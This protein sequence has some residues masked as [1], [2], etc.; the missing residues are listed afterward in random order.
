[1]NG[2]YNRNSELKMSLENIK[3]LIIEEDEI[4][5]IIIQEILE[6]EGARVKF[7]D[8][9]EDVKI[10]SIDYHILL[11]NN[12]DCIENIDKLSKLD[13]NSLTI[14]L[15]RE[16]SN[17][18]CSWNLVDCIIDKPYD[19]NKVIMSIVEMLQK[20]N[21]LS[22][23]EG[24]DIID[25]LNRIN[26]KVEKYII[27]LKLFSDRQK[28][29]ISEIEV[30]KKEGN[31]K[32]AIRAAHTLKG[33]SATIG[34]MNLSNIAK[35]TQNLLE[36]DAEDLQLNENLKLLDTELKL[37]FSSIN[38]YILEVDSNEN[39]IMSINIDSAMEILFNLINNCDT[40]SYSTFLEIKEAMFK[41]YDYILVNKLEDSILKFKW[42]EAKDVFSRLKN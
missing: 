33:V 36:I 25:G 32:D 19:P 30:L 22:N 26:N 37:V 24:I 15:A 35:E 10:N 1:M 34:A 18:L 7:I 21:N 23:Y 39:K 8:N 3:I 6:G 29:T 38:K 12:A 17:E 2:L 28:N 5:R 13:K 9:I 40:K 16:D 14:I 11:L 27:L 41:K 4:D 42:K 31:L 20:K